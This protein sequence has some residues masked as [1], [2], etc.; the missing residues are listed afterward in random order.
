MYIYIYY[1]YY[2]YIFFKIFR[3]VW[4]LRVNEN[5]ISTENAF[6]CDYFDNGTNI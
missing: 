6:N 1:V 3:R 4:W 2:V 5:K